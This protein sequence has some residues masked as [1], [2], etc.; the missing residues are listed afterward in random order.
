LNIVTDCRGHYASLLFMLLLTAAG[1]ALSPQV[2]RIHPEIAAPPAGDTATTLALEVI[3][4][5]DG[6]VL[7]RR[8]GVY[9]KTATISTSGDISAPI[10][11]SIAAAL[12]DMGYHVGDE[13]SAPRLQVVITTLEYR[14]EQNKVTRTVTTHAAVNTAVHKSGKSYTS[15]YEITRNRKMLTAPDSK[16]NEKLVNETLTA[17]LQQMLRDEELFA[18]INE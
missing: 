1:C 7:G 16:D 17:A 11:Q 8:G 2:V 15:T 3:D 18:L 6:P 14:V 4:G 13:A 9:E 10:R 12:E 5:R